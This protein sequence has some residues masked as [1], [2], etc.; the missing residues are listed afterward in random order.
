MKTRIQTEVSCV[1][2]RIPIDDLVRTGQRYF[3]SGVSHLKEPAGIGE[4]AKVYMVGAGPL[5]FE[6]GTRWRQQSL[7]A[8]YRIRQ[9][10]C[11]VPDFS[12]RVLTRSR[13]R[14]TQ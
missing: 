10:G 11:R 13:Y 9:P 14:K 2:R 7:P 5:R 8:G 3:A 1:I 4:V 6:R 12:R